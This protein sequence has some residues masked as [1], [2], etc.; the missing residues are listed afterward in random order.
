MNKKLKKR[1]PKIL[2]NWYRR[3]R[4][5]RR[6]K[7]YQGNTVVC[8]ICESTFREFAPFGLNRRKNARC[9]RCGSLERHRLIWKYM[10]E[11]TDLFQ[12]TGTSRLLHFAPEQA[13]YNVFS[14][15]SKIDYV[16]CDLSPEAYRY[17]NGP[18]ITKVDIVSIPFEDNSFDVVLCNHVLEHIPD[19][20]HAMSELYRVMKKGAW[21][22]LQ[23]PIDYSLDVTYEDFSI[24]TPKG[25]EE[26]FGQYDHV[27]FYGKDYM[28]RLKK[29][30]FEV[31]EDAFVK[32]I[33]PEEQFRYGLLDSEYLYYCQ[34]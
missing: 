26:A 21:A 18:K 34:K 4:T 23:V 24:T 11:R 31:V 22:I 32:S 10:N 12:K 16:P 7:Q 8:P 9:P 30:G 28:D 1:T 13:F 17:G 27:R 15:N 19:D 33:S 5:N 25:R 3:F 6:M 20:A 2:L 14:N 29:A